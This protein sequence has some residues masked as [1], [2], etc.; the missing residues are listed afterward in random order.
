MLRL[1]SPPQGHRAG[2]R[3]SLGP[4]LGGQRSG[5]ERPPA[6]RRIL[7]YLGSPPALLLPRSPGHAPAGSKPIPAASTPHTSLQGRAWTLGSGGKVTWAPRE[8]GGE[9]RVLINQEASSC[10]S[11]PPAFSLARSKG[12]VPASGLAS[13]VARGPG[14]EAAAWDLLPTSQQ[15]LLPALPPSDA[16]SRPWPGLLV[17]L[18]CPVVPLPSDS[19]RLRRPVKLVWNPKLHCYM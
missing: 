18:L 15:L 19:R 9:Q 5:S 8:T 16:L 17:W 10:S 7:V 6:A 14:Q 13:A 2:D 1:F 12:L 3:G 11:G 4:C